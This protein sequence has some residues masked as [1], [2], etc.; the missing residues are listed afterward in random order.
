M[1]EKFPNYV[2]YKPPEPRVSMNPKKNKQKENQREAYIIK[3]FKR[4]NT[5]CS[6]R[7]VE[8][9]CFMYRGTRL[10]I[11]AEFLLETINA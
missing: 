11:I 1:V 3:L 9:R 7:K 4:E 6:Q 8:K 2:N 10:R 5:K